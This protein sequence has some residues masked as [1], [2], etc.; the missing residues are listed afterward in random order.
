MTEWQSFN[1]IYTIYFIFLLRSDQKKL[2]AL[3]EVLKYFQSNPDN[4]TA[5]GIDIIST[6]VIMFQFRI[7]KLLD[8]FGIITAFSL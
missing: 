1:E 4:Q 2:H 5:C 7:L 3:R 6:I 8:Q